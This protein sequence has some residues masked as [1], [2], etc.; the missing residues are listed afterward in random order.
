MLYHKL[1]FNNICLAILI[2][3][4]LNH[5]SSFPLSSF[6][7]NAL[8]QCGRSPYS[9]LFL[10][11]YR[12]WSIPVRCYSLIYSNQGRIQTRSSQ[13]SMTCSTRQRAYWRMLVRMSDRET[14]FIVDFIRCPSLSCCPQGRVCQRRIRNEDTNWMWTERKLTVVWK[15]TR[16]ERSKIKDQKHKIPAIL[17]DR[18]L[19]LIDS[20]P[21]LQPGFLTKVTVAT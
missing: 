4:S 20:W 3:F 6:T 11:E 15:H 1:C 7:P 18:G 5:L 13:F 10:L 21:K 19:R 9:S 17:S 2:R 8:S 16:C 12:L 14:S